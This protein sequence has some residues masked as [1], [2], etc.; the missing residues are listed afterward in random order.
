M[1]S[2]GNKISPPNCLEEK[3]LWFGA[4]FIGF[5]LRQGNRRI[6]YQCGD[7]QQNIYLST[8]LSCSF[9]SFVLHCVGTWFQL[10]TSKIP[11]NINLKINQLLLN[12]LMTTDRNLSETPEKTVILVP[13]EDT[14][15]Y[16]DH[17]WDRISRSLLIHQ[18]IIFSTPNL[19]PV[20]PILSFLSFQYIVL[21]Q[22]LHLTLPTKVSTHRFT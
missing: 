16:S 1:D 6:R 3:S 12:C 8:W 15:I 13:W 22:S 14:D 5:W 11:E 2:N 10:E 7:F 9:P 17:V 21:N 4:S 19:L 18:V 20:K